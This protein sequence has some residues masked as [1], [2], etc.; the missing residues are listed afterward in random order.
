MSADRGVH[1]SQNEQIAQQRGVK[2]VI[3][4]QPGR[5]SEARKRH[6]KQRWFQRGRRW[7]AGVEGRISVLKRRNELDR[8][9]DHGVQGFDRWVG[10][11]VIANNLTVMGRKA[12]VKA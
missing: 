12:A 4:P 1:S 8:C 10:W 9:R 5:K 2:R 6:E 7:H 3:L 11:G